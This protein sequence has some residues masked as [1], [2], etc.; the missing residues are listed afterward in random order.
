[1]KTGSNGVVPATSGILIGDVKSAGRIGI[2]SSNAVAPAA[3]AATELYFS[4][5]LLDISREGFLLFI[6]VGSAKLIV[7]N[8][9]LDIYMIHVYNCARV[10]S[11]QR[12]SPPLENDSWVPF[13]FS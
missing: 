3:T 12:P 5:S 8:V 11:H 13:V 10:C 2:L 4:R 9:L 1:M 7:G 6:S